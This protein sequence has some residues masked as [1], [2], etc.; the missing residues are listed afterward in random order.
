MPQDNKS[1]P[2]KASI[3]TLALIGSEVGRMEA[4]G[5]MGLANHL[6]GLANLIHEGH[7]AVINLDDQGITFEVTKLGKESGV[8]HFLSLP[9]QPFE[10]QT[11]TIEEIQ[12]R[13]T[14]RRTLGRDEDNYIDD[15]NRLVDS[16]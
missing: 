11:V 3:D 14:G 5:M 4:A 15:E 10:P 7:L 16:T 13:N 12:N 2:E 8:G 6:R 1:V 9:E